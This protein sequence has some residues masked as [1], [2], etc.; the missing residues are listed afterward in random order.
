MSYINQTRKLAEEYRARVSTGKT[1]PA[2]AANQVQ[3]IRNQILEAQRIRTS[4]LGKAIAIKLKKIGLTLAE[5][6]EKYAQ[7]S[8]GSRSQA[9]PL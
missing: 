7:S 2:E 5:S 1:S 8:L 6:T 3:T 9:Y 4:D